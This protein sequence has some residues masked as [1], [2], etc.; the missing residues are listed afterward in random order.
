MF[1]NIQ[2]ASRVMYALLPNEPRALRDKKA[3]EQ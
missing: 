3:K 2:I 1:V